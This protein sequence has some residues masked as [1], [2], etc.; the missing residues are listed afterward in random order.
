MK[1]LLRRLSSSPRRNPR[2]NLAESPYQLLSAYAFKELSDDDVATWTRRFR[3]RLEDERT[4]GRIYVG[5]QGVN[6]QVAVPVDALDELKELCRSFD[7]RLVDSIAMDVTLSRKEFDASPPFRGLHVRNRPLVATGLEERGIRLDFDDCGDEIDAKT[8]HEAITESS[9][10]DKPVVL[11]CRNRYESELGHFPG[12]VPLDTTQFRESWS[13]LEDA[14]RTTPRQKEILMY[15]TG[16][17]R[18]V[19]TGSYVKQRL[20]FENVRRLRGGIVGY[21]KDRPPDAPSAFVGMNY[22]FNDR[23]GELATPMTDDGLVTDERRGIEALQVV[24]ARQTKA[25]SDGRDQA[26]PRHVVDAREEYCARYTTSEDEV[27]ANVRQTTERAFPRVRHMLSSNVQ[28]QL[29]SLCASLG[30]TRRVLELG[31]FTA[32]SALCFARVESV[33][34]VISVDSD[35]NAFNVASRVVACSSGE[36]GRKIQL[37]HAKAHDALSELASAERCDPFDVVFL[38]ADKKMY[39]RYYDFLLDS[40]L[41]RS[42]SLIVADNVLWKDIAA[43][44]QYDNECGLLRTEAAMRPGHGLNDD[45]VL[46]KRYRLL[47]ETMDAYNAHVYDDVRTDQVVLPLQDGLSLARVK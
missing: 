15:C 36:W 8:W 39:T 22:S 9:S 10:S 44:E 18:C 27:L 25:S 7:E 41:V 46:S 24:D 34:D 1:R 38:D 31:T 23:H 33:R 19:A 11:D 21:L 17:I 5:S 45:G 13:A 4:V 14:L 35:C 3:E 47:A 37:M 30:R 29:L 6:A 20:G 28:G 40:G 2:I 43:V 26:S 32:Y 42:G 12:S 16:G